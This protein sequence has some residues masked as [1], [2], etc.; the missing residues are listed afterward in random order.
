MGFLVCLFVCLF[1]VNQLF[2]VVV[3]FVVVCF[4]FVVLLLLFNIENNSMDFYIVTIIFLCV[5]SL[6]KLCK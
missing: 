3:V 4:V 2:F 6:I 5:Y 1:F